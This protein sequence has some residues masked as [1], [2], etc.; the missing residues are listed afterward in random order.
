N[1][2]AFRDPKFARETRRVEMSKSAGENQRGSKSFRDLT[3]YYPSGQSGAIKKEIQRKR[4]TYASITVNTQSE[5]DDFNVIY[6]DC[7]EVGSLVIDGATIN[8]LA[9]LN[10][11]GSVGSIII[12][13]T[14]LTDL[15][16]LQGLG[17]IYD[18]LVLENNASLAGIELSNVSTLGGLYVRNCASLTTIDAFDASLTDVAN[19]IRIENSGV[20]SLE[21]LI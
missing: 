18:S 20:A 16:D 11:I 21:G 14:S 4:L 15:S 7:D 17:T 8:S 1:N 19:D 6:P 3:I 13:N 2:S 9:T 10:N 12:R 5:I